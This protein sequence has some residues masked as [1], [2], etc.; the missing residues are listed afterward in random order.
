LELIEL[1][2]RVEGRTQVRC[3]ECSRRAGSLGLGR[4][5]RCRPCHRRFPPELSTLVLVPPQYPRGT[6]HPTLSA[7]RHLAPLGNDR[8]KV[9]T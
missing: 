4:G 9:M 8:L 2:Q 3:P 5:F 7:R 1:T 6:Y